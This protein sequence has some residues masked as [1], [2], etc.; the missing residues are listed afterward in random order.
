MTSLRPA[1][2]FQRAKRGRTAQVLWQAPAAPCSVA[3]AAATAVSLSFL[4]LAERRAAALC[5]RA[6]REEC[7][8]PEAFPLAERPASALCLVAA[9]AESLPPAES[10][11]L[12]ARPVSREEAGTNRAVAFPCQPRYAQRAPLRDAS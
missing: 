1:Q 10:F 8:P 12:A 7:L 11:P 3:G 6:A 4:L 5:L 2:S 9:S